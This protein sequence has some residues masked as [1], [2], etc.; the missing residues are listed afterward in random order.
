MTG[1]LATGRARAAENMRSKRTRQIESILANDP[2]SSAALPLL[3]IHS[4]SR[5][6]AVEPA[7]LAIA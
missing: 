6:L 3:Q 1:E 2:G 5:R 7:S 4:S